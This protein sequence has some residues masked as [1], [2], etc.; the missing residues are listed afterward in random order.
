MMPA[1]SAARTFALPWGAWSEDATVELAAPE[2]CEVELL[3]MQPAAPLT[4][5]AIDAALDAPIHAARLQELGTGVRSAVIVIDD[6]TRPTRTAE[7]LPP[8][9][10]R[11][12][13]A[14][15]A[16]DAITILIANGAH[17]AASAADLE[18]KVGAAL[19]ARFAVQ[20]HDAGGDLTPTGVDLA[21][22]P[23]CVSR[24]FAAADLR[25]GIS[26]VMPHPFAAFSGGAKLVIPGLANL[27]ALARS[28]KF[29]LMGFSGGRNPDANRFRQQMEEAVRRIGF[30][31]VACA[32][33]NDRRDT[34]GLFAGDLERAHRAAATAAAE[35]AVTHPPSSPL[36]ALILNAY[37]KDGELLQIEAAFVGLR[38][39]MFEWLQPGAP[40]VLAAACQEGLGVHRLFGP[41]GSLFR[42]PSPR[43][44]LGQ[45]PLWIYSP[46]AQE[47]DVRQ[48]FCDRYPLFSSWS[49]V[50]AALETHAPGAARRLGVVPCAPLQLAAARAS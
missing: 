44:F 33:V 41:G 19:L 47:A 25:I 9:I 12:L 37:P 24:A 13:A 8:L 6:I 4:P 1:V 14:G 17:R 35:I 50:A 23:V 5:A 45:H 34:V 39:G 10:E 46:A 21:G 36:D 43:G 27:D 48:V 42:T 22:T 2:G 18:K 49:A 26:A 40:I 11:L 38:S 28:H 16:A 29:A 15:V 3:P 32:V 30:H 7:I 31:W 20:S